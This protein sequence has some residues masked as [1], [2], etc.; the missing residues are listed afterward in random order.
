MDVARDGRRG[1]VPGR[2]CRAAGGYRARHGWHARHGRRSARRTGTFRIN[3]T[4]GRSV[5]VGVVAALVAGMCA[6]PQAVP[7]AA[8]ATPDPVSFDPHVDVATGGAQPWQAVLGDV[9]EDGHLDVVVPQIHTDKIGV[10]LGSASGTFT[11]SDTTIVSGP[12]TGAVALADVNGDHHLDIVA[13]NGGGDSVSVYFGHGDG[14]FATRTTYATGSAD[15]FNQSVAVADLNGDG[16]PDI[17]VADG[18]TNTVSVLLNNGAGTFGAATTVAVGSGPQSIVLANVT[19]TSALDLVVA[20]ANSGQV[21]V[22]P[23]HGDGTFGAAVAYPVGSAT[24]S[25]TVGDLNGDGHPDIV[26]GNYGDGTISVLLADGAGGFASAVPY[27]TGVASHSAPESVA[28]ADLNGD[29]HLD[30][31]V[32]NGDAS[33]GSGAGVSVLLG[34]GTGALSGKQDFAVGDGPISVAIADLDGDHQ[35]ELITANASASTISV[36][37]NTAAPAAPTQRKIVVALTPKTGSTQTLYEENLD[38]GS[39]QL[40]GDGQAPVMIAGGSEVLFTRPSGTS[41]VDDL[42]V[43]SPDNFAGAQ[44]LA[45]VPAGNGGYTASANGLVVYYAG[46]DGKI[47][48]FDRSASPGSQD[49]VLAPVHGGGPAAWPA[50]DPADG[51]VWYGLPGGGL[52]QVNN[53]GT[54]SAAGGVP[55]GQDVEWPS[56]TADGSVVTFVSMDPSTAAYGGVE[57]GDLYRYTLADTTVTKVVGTKTTGS[58]QQNG[59]LPSP[60]QETVLGGHTYDSY[61]YMDG[62]RSS[63]TQRSDD[64]ATFSLGF[65]DLYAPD[66]SDISF[67][68]GMEGG[69]IP[70]ALAVDDPSVQLDAGQTTYVDVLANDRGSIDPTTLLSADSHATA[71]QHDG[72]TELKITQD[73]TDPTGFSVRYIICDGPRP[74]PLMPGDAARQACRSP[75]RRRRTGRPCWRWPRTTTPCPATSASST[76]TATIGRASSPIRSRVTSRSCRPMARTSR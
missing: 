34:D 75:C 41:G 56:F 36:L 1:N 4:A 66:Y 42:L 3:R 19:D 50:V 2:L 60:S 54:S 10:L 8:G 73:S 7:N 74:P 15:K 67:S 17:A 9:N 45:Q 63:F 47:H 69:Y 43:A 68:A 33:N 61:F 65:N 51:S 48:Q 6:L 18:G 62:F 35:P 53:D 58:K 71:V 12:N 32:A 21:E 46:T 24:S 23:G 13:T 22:V 14:T 70:T 39:G 49:T 76:S 20:C 11:L 52:W 5:R 29:G 40:L 30:V 26:A 28:V 37:H 27:A 38:S 16:H 44:Q 57:V 59:V 55:A 31:A 64:G 72:K 25:V